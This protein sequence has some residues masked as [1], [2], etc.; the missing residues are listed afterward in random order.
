MWSR[1]EEGEVFIFPRFNWWNNIAGIKSIDTETRTITLKNDCSY[2]IRPNDR[3]YVQNL[4]EELDSPGEWYLDKKDSTL[5]FWPPSALTGKTVSA[6]ALQTLVELAGT[7]NVTL[8]GFTFE[9]CSGTAISLNNATSCLIAASIVR[10]VGDYNGNGIVIHGGSYN[11][12]V[13]N[14]I[15][16]IGR[17]GITVDGGDRITLT[18]AGNVA[19]N[20]Y[21]HHVGIYYKQGVG[22]D[23]TGC[24]NRA[25]HNLIH[26]TP[27]MGISYSGNNLV[28]EYNHIRHVNIETEDTGIVCTGGRDW[29]SSRGS[30]VRYNFLH[31]SLGFGQKDGKWV[32]PHF[33][34][35]VYLDDNAG[36]VD[37]I[38]NIIARCASGAIHLHNARDN[39]IQNN[40]FIENGPQQAHY[41]GV[42]GTSKM[43]LNY[44][45]PMIKGYESVVNQPAWKGMRNMQISPTEAVLPNGLVMA[46]NQMFCNIF[47]YLNPKSKLYTMWNVPLD[48]NP[49]DYNLVYHKDLPIL[50]NNRGSKPDMASTVDWKSWQALGEDT[51]SVIADPHFVDPARDDYHLLPD[52]PAFALGFKEIPIEKIG[53][54]ADELRA[55]W[56]IV[57]AEGVREHPLNVPPEN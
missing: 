37:V 7:S 42:E 22:V 56:P 12:A 15:Y 50:I 8:R 52:S 31:D 27:R 20:N 6:P 3:Y 30:T 54:Y 11:G 19:D 1:P 38:G 29:I 45:A 34:W 17:S 16:Q 53:P 9:C 2:A 39:W 33:S 36:G 28:I 23:L 46:G 49:I 13:G 32:S 47:Y 10:N 57:E 41:D 21:I 18:P 55:S 43:W 5:Y 4:F 24:G 26:D 48:H 14:D 44:T 51:H 40:I 25:S 35:G